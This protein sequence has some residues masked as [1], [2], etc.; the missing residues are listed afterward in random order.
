MVTDSFVSLALLYMHRGFFAKAMNDNPS[1]PLSGRYGHSVL[2][3]QESAS[4][5]VKLVKSL[6]SQHKQLTERNWFLFTHVFSC[7]VRPADFRDC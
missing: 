2:R 3:A 1:D 4:F 6:W 7:A 5:F